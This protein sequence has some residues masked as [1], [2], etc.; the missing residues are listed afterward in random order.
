MIVIMITGAE[1]VI[2]SQTLTLR[3]WIP[4]LHFLHHLHYYFIDV[5]IG[6]SIRC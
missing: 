3:S 1:S 6:C 4:P 5:M 2:N